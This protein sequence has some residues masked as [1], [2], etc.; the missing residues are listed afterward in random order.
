[1]GSL[2]FVNLCLIAVDWEAWFG[3]GGYVPAYIGALFLQQSTPVGFGTG[4]ELPR[5]NLLAGITDPRITIP[6]YIATTVCALLTALG[7][8]TR[9][10][11]ILLAI[12]IVTLHHRNAALLHGGDT[13]LRV[14]ALYIAIAPS[15]RACSLDRLIALWRGRAGALERVS[16]WPQRLVTYNVALIYFTTV[17]IKF[18]GTLWKS[19]VATWYPARL[20]EFERFPVPAFLE[21]L[22]MVRVTTYGTLLTEFA[23]ATLVFFRPLRTPVVVAG[24]L[25]HLYIEY[26]MNIPL[27]SF[28]MISTY[29]CFYEGEEVSAWATRVGARLKRFQVTVRYPRGTRLQPH[30]AMFLDAVD[31]LKLVTYLPGEEAAWKVDDSGNPYR[32]SF[33][34]SIGAWIWGWIPGLW[35]RTLA[36]SIENEDR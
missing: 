29:I 31:P 28:L 11:S 4:W 21:D 10:S 5:L 23:L 20:N 24:I 13:V 2:I 36:K 27:F 6:F 3:E 30:R 1:M 22:P 35:R 32:R 33:T 19:G 16:M 14:M 25:M 26:S 17:W 8:F 7:L 34:R 12:G 15:G 18:F 9:V